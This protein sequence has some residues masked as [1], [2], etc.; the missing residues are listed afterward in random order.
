MLKNKNSKSKADSPYGN[1]SN[2]IHSLIVW[3]SAFHLAV[4]D[5]NIQDKLNNCETEVSFENVER[6]FEP[7]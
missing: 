4:D 3:P 2:I 6:A 1:F 5:L 7:H